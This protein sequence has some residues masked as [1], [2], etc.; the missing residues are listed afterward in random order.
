LTE[1]SVSQTN[2]AAQGVGTLAH[3]PKLSSLALNNNPSINDEAVSKLVGAPKLSRLLLAG[4]KVT[5]SCLRDLA[6]IPT[7]SK[8]GMDGTDISDDH[9]LDV[10]TLKN[11]TKFTMRR[12]R[13]TAAGRAKLRERMP[14]LIMEF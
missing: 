5:D 12:T 2:I 13:V 4:T 8:L 1:L 6:Q 10:A 9:I 11:L 14:N 3:L 7:L